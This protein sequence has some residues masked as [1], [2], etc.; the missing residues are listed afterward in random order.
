MAARNVLDSKRFVFRSSDKKS[1]AYSIQP[2]GSRS[3]AS[4]KILQPQ[5]L[6]SMEVSPPRS[7]TFVKPDT[8]REQVKPARRVV[9]VRNTNNIHVNQGP[10]D[11]GEF[12]Q[13]NSAKI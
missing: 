10:V 7:Q 11:L 3:H 12:E 1:K 9:V 4:S 5:A 8:P 6:P 13:S 2:N